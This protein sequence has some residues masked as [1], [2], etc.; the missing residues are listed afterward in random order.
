M[1]KQDPKKGAQLYKHLYNLK[2]WRFLRKQALLRDKYKCQIDGCGKSL[3]AGRSGSSSAVVHHIIPHK[4]FIELF[5]N[6]ENLISVCKQC[7]DGPI[8]KA[9][10][11][12][13]MS[14]IGEDGWPTDQKHPTYH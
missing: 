1:A 5:L 8:A 11:R 13:Y 3:N 10:H 14:D 7:H 9:E 4:G 12:G 2:E 6:I